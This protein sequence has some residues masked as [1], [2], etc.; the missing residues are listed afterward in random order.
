VQK[1]RLKDVAE[2]A[3]V[4]VNT[5]STI[6]NRRAN[7]WAS[8]ATEE[9][10]FR[11]AAELGYRPNRAAQALRFG[12]FGSLALLVPDLSNPC[13]TAFAE[14]FEEAASRHGLD[15]MIKTW[16]N[17]PERER[18]LLDEAAGLQADGI[19]AFL[20]QPG[21]NLERLVAPG[22]SG[23]PFVVIS[24]AGEMTLPVDSVVSEFERGLHEAVG[25]LVQFGHRRFA[26]VCPAAARQAADPRPQSFRAL[27]A[28]RG[29][30]EAN[31]GIVRC[32]AT[33]AG[34]YAAATGILAAP[35]ET[36]PTAIVALNDLAAVATL[37]AAAEKELTVPLDL[38]I[39]GADDIPLA[40]FLPVSLSTISLP[41]ASMA[42]CAVEL[43]ASRIRNPTPSGRTTPRQEVY[44]T[45]FILRESIGPA[46]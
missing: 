14:H 32:R 40:A 7:S 41:I 16:R 1:V 2:R 20:G 35:A 33:V 5:A 34:T 38:S 13:H 12:R 43:L 26:F 44:P 17:D 21:G 29:I 39:V 25:T 23:T 42:G 8:K 9:R 3:G 36:R 10:V 30:A 45:T 31:C 28:A 22:R 6:L 46:P 24:T 15:V 37:R 19:A 27:L 4:A 11:A 18:R